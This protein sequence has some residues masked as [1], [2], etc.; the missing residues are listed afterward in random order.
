MNVTIWGLE[1]NLAAQAF[2]AATLI[3]TVLGYL[4]KGEKYFK[5]TLF[6]CLFCLFESLALKAYSAAACSA[7]ML[8]RN[9]FILQY[10]KNN[11]TPTVFFTAMTVIAFAAAGAVCMCFE[12]TILSA[13]PPVLSVA[14]T[15]LSVR[16][17]PLV[18]KIGLLFISSGYL[19]F[20]FY[21]GAYVGVLRQAIV[22]TAS[23]AGLIKYIKEI[24][25]SAA[26]GDIKEN[27]NENC[28]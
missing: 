23:V 24:K 9:I 25:K 7:I 28:A 10:I 8:T 14:D 19:A 4:S 13:V 12:K 11:K 26:R 6:G 18:L 21:I 27:S 20:N 5:L 17:N 2:G 1:V 3:F 16:K 15:L 22:F